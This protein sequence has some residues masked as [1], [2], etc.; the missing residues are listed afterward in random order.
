VA[1]GDARVTEK[2]YER[3]K[4]QFCTAKDEET[5]EVEKKGLGSKNKGIGEK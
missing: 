2:G 1:L 5:S 4:I 3:E